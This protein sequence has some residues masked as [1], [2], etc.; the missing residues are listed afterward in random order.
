MALALAALLWMVVV[1]EQKVEI[2]VEVPLIL[3]V[4]PRLMVVNT[5]PDTLQ[6][7]LRG[8][9]GLINSLPTREI[10]A[11]EPAAA[12]AEGENTVPVTE[13]MV[14]VPRGIQVVDVSPRRIRVVLEP[15]V[16]RE[17]E[18][19]PRVEGSLPDGLAVRRVTAIPDRVRIVGPASEVRRIMRV[20]TYPVSLNERRASFTASAQLE[21]IGTRTHAE[22]G[23][24]VSVEVEVGKRS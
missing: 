20:Q 9:K 24:T 10:R 13:D 17:V 21:P 19:Q 3:P 8:P 6:V 2:V 18:V 4:P 16:D 12:L 11:A 7:R 14:Q 15:V 5:P 23:A 1:G 22:G